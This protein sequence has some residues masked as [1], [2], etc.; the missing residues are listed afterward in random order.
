MDI[1]RF[2]P[3]RHADAELV[4]PR[5][6]V[7]PWSPAP[8]AAA[9]AAPSDWQRYATAATRYRWLVLA[10]ALAGTLAGLVAT[11]FLNPQYAARATLWIETAGHEREPTAED[12]LVVTPSW[13]TLVTSHAVMEPVV[14]RLRLFVRPAEPNDSALFTNL[15]ITERLV[16]GTYTFRVAANGT[17]FELAREDGTVVQRGTP[18]DTVGTAMGFTWLPSAA[19]LSPKRELEFSLRT[20][21]DAAAQLGRELRIRPDAGGSFVRLELR[22]TD[23][24][25]TTA[26]LNG[27]AEQ[28]VRVAAELKRQKFKELESILGEQYAY[29][30]N[31]LQSAEAALAAFQVKSADLLRERGQ[32]TTASLDATGDPTVRSSLELRLTVEDLRRQRRELEQQLAQMARGG[33]RLDA[34]NA[35]TAARESPA[36][37]AA[38]QELATKQAELRSLQYR[39]TEQSSPV[40]QLR[41]DIRE[42]EQATIPALTRQ[43]VAELQARESAIAPRVDSAFT[44][45]RAVPSRALVQARLERELANAEALNTAVGQ[46]YEAARLSLLS[47]LPDIRV[48]DVANVPHRPVADYA[49]LLVA[50][51]FLTSLLLGIVVANVRDRVDPRLRHPEQVTQEMRLPILGAIPL[52]RPRRPVKEGEPF[53]EALDAFRGLRLRVLH[54]HGVDG[55]VLLTITSPAAGEGKSFVSLNLSLAFAYAG[56]RTLLIDGD[57][58]RGGLH[59]SLRH[60]QRPGLTDVL[61]GEVPMEEA[62]HTTAYPGLSFMSSGTRMHRAPEL[63]MS[64]RLRELIDLGRD[65]YGVVIVDSPPLV[66]GID[67]LVLATATGNMLCVLRSGATDLSLASAKIDVADTLPVRVIGAVLNAVRGTGP[68]RYYTYDATDYQEVE[69]PGTAKRDSWRTLLGGK[70]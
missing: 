20:P 62:I 56:Y 5:R 36:L 42:L 21:A 52:L 44:D 45:L 1:D 60:Q 39:Y 33:P 23:P 11:R 34:L 41:K 53:A 8:S 43:V 15:V 65:Q 46:R 10:I 49:P 13:S 28:A 2:L 3:A 16:P 9:P 7:A 30:R 19:A 29:S 55:P 67:P 6:G 17:A 47:S 58:R 68:F 18:G 4:L 50:L 27:V 14:Q 35:V 22:G 26:T 24:V 32:P 63:L 25:R 31:A 51:A 61:A 70:T 64:P 54:A 57:V 37:S 69:L 40:Q 59:S 12:G 48:L 38:M 66:A